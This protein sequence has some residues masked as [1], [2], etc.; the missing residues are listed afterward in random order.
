MCVEVL[1]EARGESLTRKFTRPAWLVVF[2]FHL[3]NAHF[4]SQS[5]F[6]D[7]AIFLAPSSTGIRC[8]DSTHVQE[9]AHDTV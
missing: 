8:V 6:F 5:L 7:T 9:H 2:V 3:C 1:L 4:A